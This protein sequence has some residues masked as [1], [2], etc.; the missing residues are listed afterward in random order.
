[1]SGR[2]HNINIMYYCF[3]VSDAMVCHCPCECGA[4]I[5]ER[6]LPMAHGHGGSI[7]Y[8]MNIEYGTI[9]QSTARQ[10]QSKR[11]E[12][13]CPSATRPLSLA[14]YGPYLRQLTSRQK[15]QSKSK[16]NRIRLSVVNPACVPQC[17]Q[18]IPE[19]FRQKIQKPFGS[20]IK[21]KL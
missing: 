13:V 16:K 18:K 20:N 19:P 12:F 4:C 9:R 10:I 6:G 11:T 15:N 2:R 17:A 8:N 3:S 1:M 7:I 14:R 5:M 21:I